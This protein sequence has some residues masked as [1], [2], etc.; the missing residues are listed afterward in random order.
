MVLLPDMEVYR[1]SKKDYSN[2]EGLG[3]LYYPGRWHEVGYRVVYTSQHR[4]LAALEYLVHLS[5]A[6]L[7]QSDYVISTIYLPDDAPN[8]VITSKMLSEGWTSIQRVTISRKI[9]TNFLK[10]NT[11]LFLQVPSAIVYGEYNYI[12]NPNHPLI[13]SCKVSDISTFRFDGRLMKQPSR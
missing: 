6:S 11:N 12:I 2:L 8:E 1:I 4:S 10:P 5:S 3:G 9:G 7:L 13:V